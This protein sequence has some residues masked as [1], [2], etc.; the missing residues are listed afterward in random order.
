VSDS[1]FD[2]VSVRVPGKAHKVIT[3]AEA[4]G[5]NLRLIDAATVGVSVDETTTAKVLSAVVVAFGAAPVVEARGFELPGTVL[6]TSEFLQHPVFNA[7]RSETQLLR[8]I[9]RLSDR[10]LALDR[11]MVP[12]GSWTMQRNVP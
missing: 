1:F 3:A 4:R 2:T 10:D 5:I 6:R 8:Y 9:R 12:L 11:T 7:H